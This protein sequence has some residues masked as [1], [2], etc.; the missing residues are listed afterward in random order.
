MGISSRLIAAME[1]HVSRK[2]DRVRD[3]ATYV[4]NVCQLD[5]KKPRF[6]KA[7]SHAGCVNSENGTGDAGLLVIEEVHIYPVRSRTILYQLSQLVT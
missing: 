5:C 6:Q 7:C 2:A 4:S 1:E 3:K